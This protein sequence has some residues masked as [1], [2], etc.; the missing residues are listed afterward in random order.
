MRREKK[1]NG[2]I[3]KNLHAWCPP[4]RAVKLMNGINGN[5]GTWQGAKLDYRDPPEEL[6]DSIA[7]LLLVDP[8]LDYK[9]AQLEDELDREL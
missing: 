2:F 3:N 7:E 8:E 6:A 5:F 1:L 4:G 9:T